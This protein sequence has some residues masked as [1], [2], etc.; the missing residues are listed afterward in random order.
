LPA[1]ELLS[2]ECCRARSGAEEQQKRF[3]FYIQTVEHRADDWLLA[4]AEPAAA[5]EV[6]K[7]FDPAGLAAMKTMEQ[8]WR[9]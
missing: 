7:A 5:L 9:H 1:T 2:S 6:I 4:L 8:P 3:G